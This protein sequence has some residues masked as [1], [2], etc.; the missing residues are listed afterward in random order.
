MLARYI[1][2]PILMQHA[3]LHPSSCIFSLRWHWLP[4]DCVSILDTLSLR[5]LKVLC[6]HTPRVELVSVLVEHNSVTRFT[7]TT[8]LFGLL[9]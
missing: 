6:W 7:C 1:E 4:Q 8:N 5:L 9:D 3:N 2:I